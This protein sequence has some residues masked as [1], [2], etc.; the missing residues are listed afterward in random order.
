VPELDT[1]EAED[2]E[3]AAAIRSEMFAGLARIPVYAKAIKRSERT[4]GR[5]IKAGIVPIVRIG[6]T[7]FVVVAGARANIMAQL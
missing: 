3:L 1:N 7:P 6:K 5:M 4:V 2:A